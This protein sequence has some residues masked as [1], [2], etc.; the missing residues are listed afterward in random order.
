MRRL[1]ESGR[2]RETEMMVKR[3]G[4]RNPFR[5]TLVTELMDG[6]YQWRNAGRRA[7]LGGAGM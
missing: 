2:D 3:S 4:M 6:G 1:T 7:C 5:E